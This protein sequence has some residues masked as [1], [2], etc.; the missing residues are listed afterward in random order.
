[1]GARPPRSDRLGRPIGSADLTAQD[2]GTRT[3]VG[4]ARER[5]DRIVVVAAVALVLL[6]L[7][8][9]A[10]AVGLGVGEPWYPWSDWA[11]TEMQVR[12]V[13]RHPVELGLYSRDGW[14]H[15]G[16]ILFYLLALPYRL[17]G[18]H[19]VGLLLGALVING[20]SVV[21][22]AWL[23]RRRGGVPLL[24]CTLLAGAVVL[25]ALGADLWQDPWVCYVTTLPFGVLL[26]LSWA[27]ACGDR[28][29]LPAGAVLTTFLAQTH[30]GF[31][32]VAVPVFLW[33][34]GSLAWRVGRSGERGTGSRWSCGGGIERCPSP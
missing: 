22:M 34:A 3:A 4:A 25:S 19:P 20:A 1:M 18:G 31:V 11:L 33:G 24:L 12:D 28:W 29:A 15:P 9:S 32:A 8:V 14:G 21:A 13:G 2:E 7:V 16:P 6:P 23:A 17:V 10:A 27:M 5:G 30:V 26:F